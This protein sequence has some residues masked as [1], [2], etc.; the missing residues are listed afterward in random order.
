MNG[1]HSAALVLVACATAS[2][3][4][5][6]PQ[7]ASRRELPA[8][9]ELMSAQVCALLT[10]PPT[11]ATIER[12]P[13]LDSLVALG[14]P[15]APVAVGILCGEI[16][17]PEIVPG[18]VPESPVDGRLVELRDGVLR[19]ALSLLDQGVVVDQLA[20]RAGGDAPLEV[21]LSVAR[22][23]GE[24]RHPRVLDALLQIAAGIEPIHLSR[25]YVVQAFEEPLAR[26]LASDPRADAVLAG[27][28]GR[29]PPVVRELLLRASAQADSA[30][31][32]RFLTSRLAADEA[33]QPIVLGAIAAA[34]TGAFE[35]SA[36]ELA[37]LRARLGS[38]DPDLRRLTALALGKLED[39]EACSQLVGLLTSEEPLEAH[40]ARQALGWI[41][42]SDLGPKPA[43]WTTWFDAESAWWEELA[44]V[45][46]QRLQSGNPLVVHRAL[47]GL[48][49]HPLYRHET[50]PEVAR[51]LLDPD[52]AIAVAGCDALAALGS[53]EPL[54][55]LIEALESSEEGA[56]HDAVVRTLQALAR[57]DPSLREYL[58][59]RPS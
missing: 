33:E 22:M 54:P 25:S 55:A 39:R 17:V 4:H 46:L 5:A 31:T 2:A 29:Q 51:L 26:A 35:A 3:L 28:I 36:D 14:A 7:S 40:A 8:V 9:D 16:A 32:R 34:R 53:S 48:L 11:G 18:S 47:Q 45:E 23:L 21:R 24:A 1:R 6:S 58:A 37:A 19:E 50:A 27:R 56:L 41:A 49:R 44:P 52:E 30:A 15:L 38:E 10:S 59:K 57:R 42:G 43:P 20:R 12:K 13:L